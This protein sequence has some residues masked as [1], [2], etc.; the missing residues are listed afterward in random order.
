MNPTGE[1]DEKDIFRVEL[2]APSREALG[3]LLHNG[4]L[5]F[6]PIQQLASGEIIIDLFLRQTQIDNL[7]KAG[8]R[9]QVFENLSV[10]GHDRQMEVGAGDRFEG[11]K[12]AP[13]GL[14]KKIKEE[15]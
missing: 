11:G 5:D 10:A 2:R 7:Q 3:D 9:L 15:K 4:A 14:G 6:G 1:I 12:V 8:W 13:K